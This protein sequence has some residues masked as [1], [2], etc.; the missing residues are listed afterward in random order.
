MHVTGAVRGLLLGTGAVWLALEWRQGRTERPESVQADRGSQLVL[1]VTSVAGFAVAVALST[2]VP[3]AAISP[4][5]VAAWIGLGLLWCGVA[6]RVWSFRTLGRYFTFTVQTSRDQPVI[7]GGPY[8]VIRHPGYAALLLIIM[9][10]GLFIANWISLI[11]LAAFVVCG[12][13]YRI[14]VEERALMHDLGENYGAYAATRSRLVPF[15][16]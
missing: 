11:S 1:V 16:W 10:I 15:I 8:R 6:L 12:L 3:A 14:T 4:V 7:A 2:A 13:A 9:G 5:G